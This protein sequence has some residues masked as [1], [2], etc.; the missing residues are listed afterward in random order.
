[1]ISM[2]T[3]KLEGHR[4]DSPDIKMET[5]TRRTVVVSLLVSVIFSAALI[6]GVVLYLR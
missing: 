5:E 4:N 2:T 1:M 3:K 6:G